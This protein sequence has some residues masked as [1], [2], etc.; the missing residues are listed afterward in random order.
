M[1]INHSPGRDETRAESAT[2]VTIDYILADKT[3]VN[4]AAGRLKEA[5]EALRNLEIITGKQPWL[6]MV[7]TIID[8]QQTKL[9]RPNILFNPIDKA[10]AA[11]KKS[12]GF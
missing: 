9:D 1:L 8:F 2:M 11:F 3:T 7:I 4:T 6:T 12:G 5:K 10:I